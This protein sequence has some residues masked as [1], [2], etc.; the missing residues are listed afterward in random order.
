MDIESL[1]EGFLGPYVHGKR[2]GCDAGHSLLKEGVLDSV[3]VMELIVFMEETFSIE[4]QPE[5]VEPEIF[6]TVGSLAAYVRAKLG[7]API[8]GIDHSTQ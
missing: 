6:D 8:R 5:E 7:G 1:I 4:V 2:E 3:R